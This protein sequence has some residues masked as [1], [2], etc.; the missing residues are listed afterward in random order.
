MVLDVPGVPLSRI[1][2]PLGKPPSSSLSNPFMPVFT[3]SI[4]QPYLVDDINKYCLCLGLNFLAGCF[5]IEFHIFPQFFWNQEIFCRFVFAALA[6][7]G[8]YICNVFRKNM[9]IIH[10]AFKLGG[11][12]I[13]HGYFKNYLAIILYSRT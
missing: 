5:C 3:L 9:D 1:I 10:I 6:Y 12:F 7:V 2:F 4:L 11:F 13:I 8:F